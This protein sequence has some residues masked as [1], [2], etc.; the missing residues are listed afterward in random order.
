MSAV[1]KPKHDPITANLSSPFVKKFEHKLQGTGKKEHKVDV[2]YDL[3]EF[4]TAPDKPY[5]MNDIDGITHT[6]VWNFM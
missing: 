6:Y 1:F 2:V 5:I 4:H 3:S